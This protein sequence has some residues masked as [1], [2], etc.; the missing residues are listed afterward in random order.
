MHKSIYWSSARHRE[1]HICWSPMLR[2]RGRRAKTAEEQTRFGIDKLNVPRSDFG[3]D[4]CRLLGA[5]PDRSGR[6]QL[7]SPRLAIVADD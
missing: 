5:H 2:G 4:A 7:P 6:D 3:G 1:P